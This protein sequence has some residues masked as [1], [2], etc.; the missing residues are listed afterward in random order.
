LVGS[1]V[2]PDP[3]PLAYG[4]FRHPDTGDAVSHSSPVDSPY[5]VRPSSRIA[6]WTL[7]R[8]ATRPT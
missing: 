2:M 8:A 3:E 1:E 6:C 5:W 7:G 4:V